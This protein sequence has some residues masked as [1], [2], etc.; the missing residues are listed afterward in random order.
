[1]REQL[2]RLGVAGADEAHRAGGLAGERRE[3]LLGERVA[4][5]RDERPGGAE[6]LGEQPG[7]PAVA[8]RAVDRRL[9]GLRVEQ[10]E[11]L[12]GEHGRVR[13]AARAGTRA[14]SGSRAARAPGGRRRGGGGRAQAR[15]PTL[16]WGLRSSHPPPIKQRRR[17][18]R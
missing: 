3:A 14:P 18:A 7:V 13:P 12:A 6:P 2:E 8:E 15:T 1:M 17:H 5:D 10:L 4:V 9:P 16:G 11:Q